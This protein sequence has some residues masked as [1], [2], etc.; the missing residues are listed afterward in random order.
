MNFKDLL[1]ENQKFKKIAKN[2]NA[3]AQSISGLSGSRISYFAVNFLKK[4][5]KDI[6]FFLPD[7][8]YLQQMQEDLIRL[9]GKD[10]FLVFPEEEILP[11]EQLMPDLTTMSERTKVLTELIFSLNQKKKIIL[12]TPA[13]VFK[14]LP[15]KDIYK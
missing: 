10:E 11:H 13:A 15:P 4:A 5:E 9:I 7:N 3:S 2:I 1:L 14:K 8:Y 12:T 6:I